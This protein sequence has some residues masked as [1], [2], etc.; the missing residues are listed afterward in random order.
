MAWQLL[1]EGSPRGERVRRRVAVLTGAAIFVIGLLVALGLT[2]LVVFLAAVV[3]LA[4]LFALV[5]LLVSRRDLSALGRQAHTG[6]RHARVFG[7]RVARDTAPA[8]AAA[9]R[10]AR[11]LQ[12][13]VS[14]LVERAATR[15]RAIDWNGWPYAGAAPAAIEDRRRRALELNARGAQLRSEGRPEAAAELHRRALQI[16]RELGDLPAEAPTLNSLALALDDAGDTDAAV[17]QFEQ[18]LAILRDLD[19]ERHEGKVIANFGFTMLRHGEDDRARGLLETALDKLD[20]E[21]RAAQRVVEQLQR[22]S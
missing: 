16:F 15:T 7:R 21:S 6:Y 20:P 11:D 3:V 17:E 13:A 14:G 8:I 9:R 12:P 2:V 1:R 4:G 18:A 19:D 22:V 5:T 10:R